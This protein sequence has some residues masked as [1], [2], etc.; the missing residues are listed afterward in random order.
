MAVNPGIFNALMRPVR[1]VA[2]YHDQFNRQD[3]QQ[4]AMQRNALLMMQ[5]QQDM[6]MRQQQAQ[7]QQQG[8]NALMAAVGGVDV[9]DN[10]RLRQ[11]K[12][13]AMAGAL[14][15][16]DFLAEVYPQAQQPKMYTVGGSLVEAAPGQPA[17]PV[18]TAPEK[19]QALPEIVR[20]MQI[21][22][23]LPA[24]DPQ[25][26]MIDAKIKKDTTHA[27]AASAVSYGSPVPIMLPDGS[28]GYAQPGNRPG[29]APQVMADPTGKPLVKP[30][31]AAGG[32]VEE[33][34]AS[35]YAS[36]M[37][38][39]TKLLDTFEK[40]GRSTYGT[41][42]AAAVPFVGGALRTGV[43]TPAQQKYRQAQEDWVRAKL[44]KESGAAIGKDEMEREITTYFPQPGE[45]DAGVIEQK[46]Q[47][48]M[49]A[50]EAMTRAAGKAA[51]TSQVQ[52]SAPAAAKPGAVLKFDAQG[53]L[54]Q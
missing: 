25:R 1:S 4:Q 49:V 17:K 14:P 18:Y 11:F 27:P 51:Y 33:R 31:D 45:T 47:A 13:L 3:L 24:G 39:A 22:D 2:D 40:T 36:R 28:I 23:A 20:L 12:Q 44:R 35:G 46:R 9:G 10:P 52:P 6:Q 50:N 54:V 38:E 53:N 37:K 30:N 7:S 34:N 42:I 26:A 15:P 19:P 43:M 41:D 16:K 32:T 5:E 8:Q 48:R 29:A 21:R